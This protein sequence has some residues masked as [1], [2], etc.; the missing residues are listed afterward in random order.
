M[1]PV[2]K[3][4]NKRKHRSLA[5]S[6]KVE[7]LEK[8]DK[9]VSVRSVCEFYGIGSSTVYDIK[10]QKEKLLDFFVNSESKKQMFKRKS[11]KPGKSAQL[12]Q[13]MMRWFKL[14]ESE[15]VEL[16]GDLVKEQAK[17]FH[18]ELGLQH[19]CDYTEG[20]LQRFKDR[21]GLKFRAVCGEKRSADKDAAEQ[22]VDEF[23]K[24]V[25][26]EN[27]TP[28][29]VYNADES[30]LF[31]KCTPKRTL[32]SEDAESPTG[33]KAS[34]DRVT[35]MGCGNAAGTHRCKLLVIGKS[36][37]PRAL[38]GMTSLPVIYRANKKGWMITEL[39]LDWF[40][41]YF[42]PEA[43][44][45]CDSIGLDHNCKILLILDNC[46]AHPKA[47]LLVK[48][49]VFGVYLP[50][51]CTSLIQPMDNGIL[52]SLKS[53]YRTQFMRRLLS[54]VNS[55]KPV[56]EFIREY[57][58]RDM[59]YCVANAWNAVKPTTLKN[60][61]HKLWPSLMFE[62]APGETLEPNFT[63]FKPFKEKQ[64]IKDLLSY[65]RE[66]T[67]PAAKDLASRLDEDNIDEW[68]NVDDNAPVVHHY[69]DSEIVEMVISPEKQ[70][71][72]GESSDENEEDITER[73]SIDRLIQLTGELLKGLEQ[74]S[75]ITEQEMVFCV[76]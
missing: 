27:L 36:L 28:D 67:D 43:R 30:A 53:K 29:Q 49:N 25:T 12:D 58:V 38:K 20:W 72:E 21:H 59:I 34:K 11:M 76:S 15:G 46:S 9:G 31:W 14:R 75:F 39:S 35:I 5:I 4:S 19:Q 2:N 23:A 47:E 69:T 62:T 16:S 45:H 55:G 7:L 13:V 48:D 41:N 51:N 71:S 32:K 40:N 54:E 73:I 37:H 70:A 61:W 50:P 65:A 60:G 18:E 57:N 24:L 6:E 33:Y 64:Q 8:L 17:T 44:A 26:D 63:G 1:A 56:R 42:V 10:K 74:R 68:M 52:R 3:G 22:F 66:L